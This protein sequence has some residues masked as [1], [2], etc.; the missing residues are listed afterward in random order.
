MIK[1]YEFVEKTLHLIRALLENYLPTEGTL[2]EMIE[3]RNKLLLKF[4]K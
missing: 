3:K 1:R 4:I 2:E